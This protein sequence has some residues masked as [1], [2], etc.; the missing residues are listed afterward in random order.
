MRRPSS[1]T[2]ETVKARRRRAT[3]LKR[4]NE[5]KAVRKRRPSIADLQDKLGRRTRERDE[6]IEQQTAT[7]EVLQVISSPPGDLQ[8]VFA[9]I[10]ENAV[11]ISEA[12]FGAL[13]LR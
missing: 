10:L 6:A 9:T 3:T 8:L 2:D 1:T 12:K 4:R 11:R 13:Y 5:P 7:S